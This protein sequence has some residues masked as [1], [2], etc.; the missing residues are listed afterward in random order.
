MYLLNPLVII[1]GS[2]NVHF[3]AALL[4]FLAI[5]L[6]R[7]D[8]FRPI[9]AGLG[10]GAAVLTK[11]NPLIFLPAF[12]RRFSSNQ[13]IAFALS[14]FLLCL[15]AFLPFL[16]GFFDAIPGYSLYFRQFEFNASFYYLISELAKSV[17]DYNPIAVLGPS[18]GVLA[19]ASILL[20]AVRPI[21][22]IEKALLSYLAFLLFSTTVH[23]WYLIPFVFLAI[24][25]RRH[26]LLIWSFTIFFSY[27]HYVGEWMPKYPWIVVEYLTLFIALLYSYRSRPVQLFRG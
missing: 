12:Y 9:G 11:L 24:R 22:L 4:P 25:A 13:R 20:I 17:V 26:V 10:L 2:G 5:G 14:F 7:A 23:P 1:E 8:R 6:D 18:M 27:S 19:T 3:E 16:R 15:V 21:P